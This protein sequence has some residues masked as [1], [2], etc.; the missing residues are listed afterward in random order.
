MPL[1]STAKTFLLPPKS[2]SIKKW[3][4]LLMPLQSTA[5]TFVFPPESFSIKMEI[6]TSA[7]NSKNICLPSRV[8]YHK[9]GNSD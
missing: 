9:N 7:I 4:F 2:F 3:K 8:F 1:Q 6:L 5:K